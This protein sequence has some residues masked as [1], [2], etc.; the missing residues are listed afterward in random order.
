MAALSPTKLPAAP[1]PNPFSHVFIYALEPAAAKPPTGLNFKII[2]P[3]SVDPSTGNA[4]VVVVK[5]H[6]API[7]RDPFEPLPR[8]NT[9]ETN[10]A[11]GN[12]FRDLIPCCTSAYQDGLDGQAGR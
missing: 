10:D 4:E 1:P 7:Q 3:S 5:A 11:A 12:Q 6:R 8:T 2:P 9:P